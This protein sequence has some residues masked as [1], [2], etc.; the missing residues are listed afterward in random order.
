MAA[1]QIAKH[2]TDG[3]I[4]LKDGTGTPVTLVVPF[5]MGDFSISGLNQ[6]RRATNVYETRGQLVSLRKGALSFPTGSFSAM[7]ADYSD[8]TN[9]TVLDFLNK[10][11]SYSAND[12]TTEALG[13]V[14]T[15]DILLTVEG[16]D[17][18]DAADHVITLEDCDCSMDISE[19]EP[20]SLSVSFTVYGTVSMT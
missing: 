6:A 2:F 10:A 4:T 18:G 3:T 20:N 14:Y 5:S 17:L 15:V 16:T 12:S 13:D 1:S 11:G 9:T 8:A 7:I 19:G